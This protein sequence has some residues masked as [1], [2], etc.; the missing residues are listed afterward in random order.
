MIKSILTATCPPSNGKESDANII[1]NIAAFMA[2]LDVSQA[3]GTKTYLSIVS[4]INE[5]NTTSD[6][7]IFRPERC[8]DSCSYSYAID[9]DYL[10]LLSQNCEKIPLVDYPLDRKPFD[11][12]SV[13]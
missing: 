13:Y 3:T 8:G 6:I 12:Y 7:V 4:T 10:Y 11:P 9:A 5:I 1:D 2:E